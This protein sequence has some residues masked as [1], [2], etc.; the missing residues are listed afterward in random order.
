MRGKKSDY[1]I[2]VDR[3]GTLKSKYI[4]VADIDI[5]DINS[6]IQ[7]HLQEFEAS[8]AYDYGLGFMSGN[9][10]NLTPCLRIYGANN[11]KIVTSIEKKILHTL[12]ETENPLLVQ[13][14]G[15]L[16]T[17]KGDLAST[18]FAF[19]D[20]LELPKRDLPRALVFK[21]S[22]DIDLP[23]KFSGEHKAVQELMIEREKF[24]SSSGQE[25][26]GMC[27]ACGEWKKLRVP[28]NYGLLT[29]DQESFS[30]GFRGSDGQ[31]QY[32][33]CE[34]CYIDCIHGYNILE[35]KLKFWAYS[36]DKGKTRIYY[37]IIPQT[38]NQKILKNAVTTIGNAKNA[39]IEGARR[40]IEKEIKRIDARIERVDRKT[41]SQLERKKKRLQ[42]R[43]MFVER[44]DVPIIIDRIQQTGLGL[45]IFYFRLSDQPGEK[46]KEVVEHYNVSGSHLKELA[47]LF[48]NMRTRYARNEIRLWSL[49]YL[50]GDRMFLKILE[51]L[52]RQTKISYKEFLKLSAN[53]VYEKFKENSIKNPDQN[54]PLYRIREFSFFDDLLHQAGVLE[55]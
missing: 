54:F 20:S 3:Y 45:L 42:N 8:N 4:L 50:I 26:E 10:S 47:E 12:R 17:C 16:E 33:V 40:N 18:I 13:I 11:Q 55:V 31:T 41:R 51:A 35:N 46:P 44:V 2:L 32:M 5:W 22:E 30:V 27:H 43:S 24:Y 28:F 25:R 6:K 9:K 36:I 52:F 15:W 1:S 23:S 38:P 29:F 37:Y 19:V 7:I 53:S 49:R 14:R 39:I 21:F 34:K 48:S